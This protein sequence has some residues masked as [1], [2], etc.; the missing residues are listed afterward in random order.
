[1][2][3]SHSDHARPPSFLSLRHLALDMDGTLYRGKRLFDVTLP[4]LERLQQLGI[5]YTLLTNNT[6]LSKADYV[7]KLRHLGVAVE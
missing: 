1:M 2:T 5:G 4:F 7:E 3:S 6:S